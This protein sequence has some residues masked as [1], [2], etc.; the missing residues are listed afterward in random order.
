M[1]IY[2]DFTIGRCFEL[3]PRTVSKEEIVEFAKEFDPQPFHLDAESEQAK[4]V[5]GLIASGWHTC[6][7]FMRMMCDAYIL[8]TASQGSAGLEEVR[9]LKPV[10][11][12][13]TLSGTAKVVS[14]RVSK[15]NA[16]LGLVGLDYSLENQKGETV[17]KITG[18]AMIDTQNQAGNE[19]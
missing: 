5:G 19:D 7:I 4:Q 11:P 12:N 6:S 8:D 16:K 14:R 1:L 17:L 9:W 3:G 10:R 13:D 15:S 2:D 18:M